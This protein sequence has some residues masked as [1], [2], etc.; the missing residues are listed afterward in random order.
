MAEVREFIVGFV[1]VIVGIVVAVSLF[2]TLAN[3][4]AT[5]NISGVEKAVIGIVTIIV[6]I[7]ILMFAVKALV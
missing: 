6:A 7:G 5:A 3:T 2:P 4:I 1:G